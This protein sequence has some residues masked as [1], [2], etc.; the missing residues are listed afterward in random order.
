MEARGVAREKPQRK[1]GR[2]GTTAQKYL[3]PGDVPPVALAVPIL[4]NAMCSG[5][6]GVWGTEVDKHGVRMRSWYPK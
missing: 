1:R 6:P 5:T 4:A 2:T 3:D